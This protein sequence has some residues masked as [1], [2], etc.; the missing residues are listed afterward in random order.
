MQKLQGAVGEAALR[1]DTQII[2]YFASFNNAPD[3]PLNPTA[4]ADDKS[5]MAAPGALALFC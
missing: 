1:P 5:A 2:L 3:L 4:A